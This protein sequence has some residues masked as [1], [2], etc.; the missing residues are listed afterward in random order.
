MSS[1]KTPEFLHKQGSS[2]SPKAVFIDRNPVVYLPGTSTELNHARLPEPGELR[3]MELAYRQQRSSSNTGGLAKINTI[4][5]WSI[6]LPVFIVV[7]PQYITFSRLA[8]IGPIISGLLILAQL[9]RGRLDF[10][11]ILAYLVLP[12]LGLSAAY[13]LG[14]L[15]RF[16]PVAAVVF[17]PISLFY[18]WTMAKLPFDFYNQWAH[19]H[20]RLRPETR[21]KEEALKSSPRYLVFVVAIAAA[22]ILPLISNSLAILVVLGLAIT[23]SARGI[24]KAH[25]RQM[26]KVVAVFATYAPAFQVPGVW[27]PRRLKIKAPFQM[28][29][30]ENMAKNPGQGFLL[31]FLVFPVV[32][33]LSVSLYLYSF[34]DLPGVGL[35][36]IY[37]EIS[38][39]F[40][41]G[42]VEV[43]LH[44]LHQSPSAWIVSAADAAMNDHFAMLWVFPIALALAFIIPSLLFMA[45]YKGLLDETMAIDRRIEGHIAKD[46]TQTPALDDDGRTEWQWYVDRVRPSEH[47]ATDPLGNPVREAEH[48]FLGIEPNADI[49]ILLDKDILKEHCYMAGETGSGKTA[50]GIAPMLI[51]LIRGHR[52]AAGDGPPDQSAGD[53]AYSLLAEDDPNTP[54]PPIVIMDLKGDAS[55]FNTVRAEAKS[56]AER[57]GRDLEDV[58]KFFTP[59]PEKSTYLFNPLADFH[60]G[61]RS[62][63][64][65]SQL[66]LDSLG[67]SHGE[68][69]GRSYYTRKNRQ[70]LN[71]ALESKKDGPPQSIEDLYRL[72]L[73]LSKGRNADHR[74]AFELI[75][76]LDALTQYDALSHD[77]SKKRHT[78][79]MPSVLEERQIIYFW[80]PAAIET[81]SV[82]EIGKMA[83]FSLLSAAIDRQRSGKPYRQAYLFIDEFQRLAGENFKVI[84]EQARS[85]GIANI[86][87][88]QTQS[89][90]KT[91]DS[92]LRQTVHTNTRTK[93]YF[94]MTDPDEVSALSQSSGEEIA[95]M[96]SFTNS[97]S[98]GGSG[99]QSLTRSESLKP[100]LMRNDI[101]RVTDHPLEFILQVSRGSGYTQFGGAAIPVR[102]T[103]PLS[104]EEYDRRAIEPWPTLEQASGTIQEA[105]S[106]VEKE[107]AAHNRRSDWESKLQEDLDELRRE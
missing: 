75:S 64:Q 66:L 23:F 16:R 6:F 87:A 68:G 91:P 105:R 57:T 60:A 70:L 58:F 27:L 85:F 71:A 86:L 95:Y 43:L 73:R 107:D 26:M 29:S 44:E 67:L 93:I 21:R 72:A 79:H 8:S 9:V 83:I 100:R 49:P 106:P 65:L 90:L 74:D 38:D 98:D 62:L 25:F 84:L 54:S 89:D 40:Y 48:L 96:R 30:Y 24:T 41:P 37:S 13:W 69:Y 14:M 36:S 103:Y 50:L 81:V 20:P 61:E 39:Q 7:L 2:I 53:P 11:R 45:F 102:S 5:L 78:I 94:S 10:G 42:Q 4:I 55:L 59:E 46:G 12:L 31:A 15:L 76:T 99:M 88:N 56:W 82:R 22:A 19:T 101:M 51:Q 18:L 80:L 92:D 3:G 33:T 34:W 63:P 17:G 47:V 32:L 77:P 35:P 97:V 104:R 28:K 52:R 1:E